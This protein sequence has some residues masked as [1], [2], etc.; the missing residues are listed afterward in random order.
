MLEMTVNGGVP[1]DMMRSGAVT[2]LRNRSQSAS[3]QPSVTLVTVLGPTQ[4]PVWQGHVA[5]FH[6]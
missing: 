4:K 5:A 1:M 3:F 2:N 6:C